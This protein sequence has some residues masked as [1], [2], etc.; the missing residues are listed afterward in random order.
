MNESMTAV[1]E[2]NAR[3]DSDFATEPYEVAWATEARWFFV[4][5]DDANGTMELTTEIS[6]DGLNWCSLDDQT[7]VISGM[8]SWAERDFGG[9]LR[10]RGSVK[11]TTVHGSLYLVLKA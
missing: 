10:L 4:P 5:L 1:I 6:P 7:H 2:R 9:W 3:F 8:T 11:D